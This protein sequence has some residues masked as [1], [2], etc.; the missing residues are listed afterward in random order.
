MWVEL[1]TS[2]SSQIRWA[3]F[4]LCSSDLGGIESIR[5]APR[6]MSPIFFVHIKHGWNEMNHVHSTYDEYH[7]LCAH[8]IWVELKASFLFHVWW[9]RFSSCTSDVGEIESIIFSPRPMSTIFFLDIGRG[10]NWKHHF[11]PTSN[12]HHFL[13]A[14]QTWVELKASFSSHTQWTLFSWCTSDVGEIESII[15]LPRP[16]S[17]VS[18]LHIG[19]GW[20]WKHHF[21]PTSDEHYFLCAHQT[22]VELKASFSSHVRCALF[23]SCISE[24]GRIESITFAPRLMRSVFFVLIRTEWNWK[25]HFRPTSD[26]HRF[27]CA[28]QNWVDTYTSHQTVT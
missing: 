8:Q 3:P 14:H 24:V 5:F 12:E 2:F 9:A 6:L 21:C 27:L 28:H 15:F 16:M 26:E 13:C 22:W 11:C 7:F 1:K 4:S 20:N 10:W 19:R 18:F 25:H 17:T 23:S